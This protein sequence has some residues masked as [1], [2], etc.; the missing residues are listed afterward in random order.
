MA[1]LEKP[2]ALLLRKTA[3]YIPVTCSELLCSQ[4]QPFSLSAI[5]SVR[6][7]N[8]LSVRSSP[9]YFCPLLKICIEHVA[10]LQSWA[11]GK[12]EPSKTQMRVLSIYQGGVKA[13][14][15]T[16]C[17]CFCCMFLVFFFLVSLQLPLQKGRGR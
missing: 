7:E 16:S 11:G 17:V 12:K 6:E 2:I 8:I 10:A 15:P 13:L 5:S 14:S 4:L 3:R 1:L 9:W